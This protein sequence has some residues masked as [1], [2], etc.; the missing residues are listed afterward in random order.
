MFQWQWLFSSSYR[1]WNMHL[2]TNMIWICWKMIL[3]ISL[4]I[5]L[6]INPYYL[7]QFELRIELENSC[8]LNFIVGSSKCFIVAALAQ[9]YLIILWAS[10]LK[11]DSSYDFMSKLFKNPIHSEAHMFKCQA[12]TSENFIWCVLYANQDFGNA[13]IDPAV[14]SELLM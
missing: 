1:G 14:K 7:S 9:A 5:T 8:A 6:H 13:Q 12:K 3:K 2:A 11:S 10:T 4:H